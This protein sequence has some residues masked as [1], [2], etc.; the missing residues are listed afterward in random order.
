MT[1]TPDDTRADTAT[2]ARP[3]PGEAVPYVCV[4]R[5]RLTPQLGAERAE[6]ERRPRPPVPAGPRGAPP[7]RARPGCWKQLRIA[8]LKAT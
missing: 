3:D 5:G 8:V 6:T 1:R 7:R 2:A 4:E